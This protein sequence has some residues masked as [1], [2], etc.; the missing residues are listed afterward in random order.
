MQ[1]PQKINTPLLV[2]DKI[3]R[4]IL[5]GVW[6]GD[7]LLPGISALAKRYEVGFCSV[8][9]A[10]RL[11]GEEGIILRRNGRRA[12]IVKGNHR[13]WQIGIVVDDALKDFPPFDYT[14]AATTFMKFNAVQLELFNKGYAGLSMPPDLDLATY[15][16]KLDG[17]IVLRDTDGAWRYSETA[18]GPRTVYCF[19]Q[20]PDTLP[21]WCNYIAY[22]NA[23]EKAATVL[24]ARGARNIVLVC[25]ARRQKRFS[26][27]KKALEKYLQI[28][29]SIHICPQCMENDDVAVLA[30]ELLDSVQT[31]CGFVVVGDGLGWSLC[32]EALKRKLTLKKDVSVIG[33]AGLPESEQNN[34]ALSVIEVPVN[35]QA[36]AAVMQV[37][38]MLGRAKI[39]PEVKHIKIEAKLILRDS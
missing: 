11:L 23:F 24:A 12:R 25:E 21:E 9:E 1:S 8:A 35:A 19:N 5:K 7:N 39:K 30:A 27:V 36:A 17:A 31:P 15:L 20:Q 33:T 37:E 22:E 32:Q 18:S 4:D 38:S 28:N 26:V 6:S 2:R 16:P 10:V 3:F 14:H 29:C 34:P 13:R